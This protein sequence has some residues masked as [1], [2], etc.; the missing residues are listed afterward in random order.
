MNSDKRYEEED[1]IKTSVEK[2]GIDHTEIHLDNSDF[3]K[4]MSKIIQ[5]RKQPISTISYYVHWLLMRSMNSAGFKVSFS[6]TAADEL[7]SGYYDHHNLYL[8]SIAA[9]ASN[10]KR[11]KWHGCKIP[12][13]L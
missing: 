7:F 13:I 8:S 3:L 9:D 5:H 11:K 12:A 1:L 10:F 2:L 6:G 4:N